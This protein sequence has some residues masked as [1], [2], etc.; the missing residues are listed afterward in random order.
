[1]TILEMRKSLGLSQRQFA[2]RFHLN[3]KTVQ[4]WEGGW[5]KTPE[6]YLY[7]IQRVIELESRNSLEEG[8]ISDSS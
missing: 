7:L 8:G 6:S 4:S 5:R 1:M 2:D 3:V